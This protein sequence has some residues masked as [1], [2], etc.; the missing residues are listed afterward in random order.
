LI[1]AGQ[2]RIPVWSLALP[3]AAV[4]ASGG[5]YSKN[6]ARWLRAVRLGNFYERGVARLEDRWHGTGFSGEEFRQPAHVYDSDLQILG[7]GSVFEL[8]C[9]ARTGIGR[10]RLAEYLLKPCDLG[11]PRLASK[12]YAN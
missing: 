3:V 12:P 4:V 6:K 1:S 8:L 5:W 11:N 7:S 9:T 2:R 10:R